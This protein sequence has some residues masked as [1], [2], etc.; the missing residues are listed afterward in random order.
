ME[1]VQNRAKFQNN[2]LELS[3]FNRFR[4]S[5]PACIK[6]FTLGKRD[7]AREVC[8]KIG[9]NSRRTRHSYKVFF[10]ESKFFRIAA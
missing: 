7:D 9:V 3:H 2:A 1:R 4:T 10:L 6:G 8:T 5:E